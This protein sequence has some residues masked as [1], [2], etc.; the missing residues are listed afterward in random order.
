MIKRF[1]KNL[2][3]NILN[4][5]NYKISKN[6]EFPPEA[7]EEIKKF[8]KLS[9]QYSMTSSE[10]MYLLSEA[11]LN[12]KNQKI[13]GD[14]VECGV[15]MGGNIL[16]YN[17]LN[18]FYNLNK[19]IYGYDTFDGMTDPESVDV[20]FQ[21]NSA[22]N[23]MKEEK[24]TENQR[25]VH[26]YSKIDTV[27][28]NI[29]QHSNLNNINLIQGPVEKTLLL[30]KNI[31]DKISILR[32]DTDFFASTKIELEVLYP[33]LVS[34]GILII[35]DYGHWKGQRK[36]VDDFFGKNKWLHIVDYSCRYL[37]KN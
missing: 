11:V 28:N 29:L 33:K 16:L 10:R 4:S 12:I 20:D 26:C 8:I 24:K 15:W 35:D 32:L 3:I 31:P 9:L 27:K 30:E 13:E 17:L 23:L 2:I 19:S 34:G 1:F 36:A 5:K 22:E 21:N 18:E 14:F 6:L 25:G 7:N 37:I